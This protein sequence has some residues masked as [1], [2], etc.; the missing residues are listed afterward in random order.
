MALIST[1]VEEKRTHRILLVLKIKEKLKKLNLHILSKNM[2]QG[3]KLND[4]EKG[5]SPQILAFKQ[6]KG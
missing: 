3:R 4:A 1:L 5:Q 6:E 2:L